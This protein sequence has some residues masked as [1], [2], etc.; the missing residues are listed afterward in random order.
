M[1]KLIVACV[2][3]PS[4]LSA[5]EGGQTN[6]SPQFSVDGDTMT[7]RGSTRTGGKFEARFQRLKQ[8]EKISS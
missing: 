4:A 7:L 8:L 1:R 6:Q 3:L 5:A 2:L